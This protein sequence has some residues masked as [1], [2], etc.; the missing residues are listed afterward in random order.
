M[1]RNP[2]GQRLYVM[3]CNDLV[4]IGV[5]RDPAS[6]RK[7]LQTGNGHEITVELSVAWGGGE[8]MKD[9]ERACHRT[10]RFHRCTGEWFSCSLRSAILCVICVTECLVGRRVM[11]HTERAAELLQKVNE[12]MYSR[13]GPSAPRKARSGE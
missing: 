1:I 11:C 2:V 4:K 9:M 5:A 13:T 12:A 3:S 10:L 7:L 6:R 8:M